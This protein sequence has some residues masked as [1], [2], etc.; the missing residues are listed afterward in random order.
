MHNQGNHWATRSAKAP[1]MDGRKKILLVDDDANIRKLASMSLEKVGGMQVIAVSSGAEAL[2][3]VAL[4]LP[5]VI[6]L[7]LMM[8]GL[9]GT[10]TLAR[11]K[12]RSD[13]AHIPVILMTA[14]VQTHEME[15]LRTLGAAGIIIKPF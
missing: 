12:E 4:D 10:E 5:D 13:T 2:D 14:K 8:P 6:V 1:W 7:D 15:E 11:L 3:A 9:D